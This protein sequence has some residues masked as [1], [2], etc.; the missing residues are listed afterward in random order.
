MLILLLIFGLTS[1]YA[2]SHSLFDNIDNLLLNRMEDLKNILGNADNIEN[3]ESISRLPNEMIYIYNLNGNLIRFYGFFVE[4]KNVS[5]II[6]KV[7]NGESFFFTTTTNFNWTGRFYA[8][9]IEIE[10]GSSIV[11][12]I[13]RFIDE[14]NDVLS[15]LQM[16]LISTG[17]LVTLLGGIGG[18]FFAN[19]SLKPVD[20][21]INIAQNIEENN[22]NERIEIKSEDELGRLA[23]TLNQ[24]ISRLEKAFEQQKQFTADVS[25]DLRTPLSII[26]AE[27]SLSLNKDRSAQEYRK[28]LEL[29]QEEVLYMSNII[30]KLLFLAR[31]DNKTQLYNFAQTELKDLILEVMRKV[32]PLYKKKGLDLKI[33]KLEDLVVKGDREKLKEALL[34]ILD[35]SLKYT[36]KGTVSI[37]LFKKSAFA[38]LSISDTGQGIPEQNLPHIFDRFYRVDKARTHSE[39]STGL[40]LAIVKEIVEAHGGKIKV[41]S[42]VGEGSTFSIFLP[43]LK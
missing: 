27:A 35:N 32:E 31:S 26:Q 30:D 15:R 25:H 22:L 34:N 39:K 20:K 3:I 21:I 23:A 41:E 5:Q 38:V 18:L 14:I 11:I 37:S 28:S 42:K 29:I 19:R 33:N 24:M 13:G 1:Y 10:D 16:I 40:G 17:V 9:G 12:I 8:S 2:L 4:L 43:L 36:E 7:A 6:Q